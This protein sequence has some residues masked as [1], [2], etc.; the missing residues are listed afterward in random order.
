[1]DSEELATDRRPKKFGSTILSEKNHQK[2]QT[3]IL[4][5]N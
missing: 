1:M 4:N 3:P 2:N 5:S